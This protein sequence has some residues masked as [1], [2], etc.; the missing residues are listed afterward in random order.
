MTMTSETPTFATSLAG[1]AVIGTVFGFV[2]R[3][4]SSIRNFL[5]SCMSV[6]V[7]TARLDDETTTTAVLAYLVRNHAYLSGEKTYGGRHDCFRDGKYGHI[8]FELFGVKTLT[9]W[10]GWL[11]FWFVIQKPAA[12]E[13]KKEVIYW[14]SKPKDRLVA[15]LMFL[16]WTLDIDHIVKEASAER[17]RLYWNSDA[18]HKRFFVK[19][20]PDPRMQGEAKYSIGSGVAWFHEGV[21]RLLAHDPS[22]LGRSMTLDGEPATDKLYFPP[23]VNELIEEIRAWHELKEWYRQRAIPWK[24]GW[25]LYGPPGTGK[26]ALVRAIAEDL[27]MPLFVYALGTLLDSELEAAWQEMQ[28][29]VPCVALIEDFDTVFHGR[30][31]IYGKPTL[32]DQIASISKQTQ[33]QNDANASAVLNIGKLSF[34][35]LLNCL[36]GVEKGGGIFTIITTNHIDKLDPAM[37]QPRKNADG[38]TEFI[39]TRP[40]RID[41]AIELGYM[42]KAGKRKLAR[43][44]F[45]DNEEGYALMLR[46]IEQEPDKKETPAQFQERC[47]QLALSLLW[48]CKRQAR[49]GHARILAGGLK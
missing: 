2:I 19:K 12:D 17:N 28:A 42:D 23:H 15:S 11:P 26:T 41:K 48:N 35:C 14:G 47:T 27:D 3:G 29:H 25:C 24:R 34:G 38:T 31:N 36:D 30:E 43:R 22:Q 32:S 18:E 8:P 40:G 44:I 10:R 20:V 9:F 16:R 1:L 33:A 39:S 37:G 5:Q 45:F 7:V 46:Q 6:L 4:W 21:Y 49:N 13:S